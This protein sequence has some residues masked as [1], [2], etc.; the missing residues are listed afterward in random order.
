MYFSLF[1]TLWKED[2]TQVTNEYIEIEIDHVTRQISRLYKTAKRTSGDFE[3][4]MHFRD[5]HLTDED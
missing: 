5:E 3:N 1:I 2:S 4:D